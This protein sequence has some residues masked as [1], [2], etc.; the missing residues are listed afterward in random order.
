MPRTRWK[1]SSSPSSGRSGTAP[2][3]APDSSSH[4][5]QQ[6]RHEQDDRRS[7][8]SLQ[9]LAGRGSAWLAGYHRRDGELA[10]LR[11]AIDEARQ[12]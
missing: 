8:A 12:R 5:A 6:R 7:R 1:L 2:L 10:A 4:E 9:A 11:A 3:E